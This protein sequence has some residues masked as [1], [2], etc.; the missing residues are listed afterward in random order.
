MSQKY[1]W[2]LSS[3][4]IMNANDFSKTPQAAVRRLI[5][6]ET[7]HTQQMHDIDIQ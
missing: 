1:L 3:Q 2:D 4:V 6:H 7:F 5:F